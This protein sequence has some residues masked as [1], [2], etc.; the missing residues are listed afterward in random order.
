[1][2]S[3]YTD[4]LIPVYSDWKEVAYYQPIEAA[5]SAWIAAG[6][7]SVLNRRGASANLDLFMEPLPS[8]MLYLYTLNQY[9][10][11]RQYLTDAD[12]QQSNVYE[13]MIANIDQLF[14]TIPPLKKEQRAYRGLDQSVNLSEEGFILNVS[15]ASF[16]LDKEVA[17]FFRFG[18]TGQTEVNPGMTEPGTLLVVHLPPGTPA[19]P[20]YYLQDEEM[21]P[22][23]EILLPRTLKL[24]PRKR[25]DYILYCEIVK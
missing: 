5:V 25:V 24:R 3:R 12:R 6:L 9:S 22:E 18:Q 10:N 13:W 20:L 1:M 15:Y 11:V 17:N 21:N 14:D 8:F 16:T 23:E 4:A 19:L 2:T 7:P